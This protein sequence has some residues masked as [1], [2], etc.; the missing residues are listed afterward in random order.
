MSAIITGIV[1]NG[2]IVPAS[3][4]KEG[5]H[6][7]IYVKDDMHGANP[8]PRRMSPTELRKLP[9][10]ERRAILAASA[11]LAEK[12]YRND[13]DFTGFD[14]FSEELDDESE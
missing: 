14:A 3:P 2:F 7:E 4:L 6:V 13:K 9:R 1:T 8:T 10:E 5:S 11:A 12:I